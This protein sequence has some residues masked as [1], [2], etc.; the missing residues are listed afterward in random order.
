M[1]ESQKHYAENFKKVLD[2][3]NKIPFVRNPR[4]SKKNL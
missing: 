1:S 4:K 3:K 2:E